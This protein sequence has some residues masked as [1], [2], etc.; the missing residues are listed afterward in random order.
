[1]FGRVRPA[2]CSADNLERTPSKLLKDHSLS[3]FESTLARLKLGSKHQL[4][5]GCDQAV[6]RD[7]DEDDK[8]VNAYSPTVPCLTSEELTSPHEDSATEA[9]VENYS[10]CQLSSKGNVSV[11][12]LFSKYHSSRRHLIPPCGEKDDKCPQL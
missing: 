3:V 8:N 5:A 11:A 9:A 10:K 12:Y 2:T 6:M 7:T 4:D 1:M